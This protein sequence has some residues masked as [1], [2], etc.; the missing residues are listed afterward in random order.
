MK[1]VICT[2]IAL[3]L[4]WGLLGCTPGGEVTTPPTVETTTPTP[5]PTPQFTDEEQAV[6]DAVFVYL[7]KWTYLAQNVLNPEVDLNEIWEVADYP[8]TNENL[9]L[10][11]A[12][13]NLG[14]QL[15]GAPILVP[16][17]VSHSMVDS[18]GDHF[19]VNGCYIMTEGYLADA[20]GN[21]PRENAADRLAG[22]FTVLRTT[23]GNYLVLEDKTEETPC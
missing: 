8:A 9:L 20:S 2:L 19:R 12:W 10:W 6:I 18:R 5:T 15:Y 1:R 16:S 13:R 21:N 17:G 11:A 23:E 3:A 14:V 4:G 22:W 7:E